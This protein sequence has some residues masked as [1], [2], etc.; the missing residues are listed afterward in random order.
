M[1]VDAGTL[2]A[3]GL[4]HHT[5]PVEVRELLSMDE[6]CVR[7]TLS[8]IRG[9][10][11]AREAFLLST[12]NRV[13]LYTVASQ[14]DRLQDYLPRGRAVSKY[15][16]WHQGPEAVRHLMRVACA[17]DSLVL[18]EP[19]I[20]GQVKS[21]MRLAQDAGS[22]GSLLHPLTRRTLS[23]AKRVRTETALGRSRVGIGNAGVD[24]ALQVFGGLKGKRA[25]L[26]GVG[27]MGRQVA[28]SLLGEGLD[29]LLV[30]NRT[31]EKAVE[32]AR[33]HGGTAVPWDRVGDYLARVDIAIAATGAR[34]HVLTRVMVERALRAR[35][36]KPIFL[37][38]LSVPRNIAADVDGLDEAYLFNV[39]DLE[40]V[41]VDGRAQRC[42]AAS[43]AGVLVDGEVQRFV[44]SLAELDL[45]KGIGTMT[46]RAEALRLQEIQR[47]HKLMNGLDEAQ[48]AAVDTLTKAL[49]K[50]LL[51]GQIRVMKTGVRAG[52]ASRISAI[53]DAWDEDE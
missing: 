3:V 47:S 51:R 27:E 49:V 53:V 16:Y 31:P 13:E 48:R 2:V 42:D 10:G 20:L 50:K 28:Q 19:Q 9:D 1:G 41:V 52:D 5:A 43:E 23:V 25:M 29:E 44:S 8:R 15:L 6:A 18:G 40:Q 45:G 30:T 39:D 17:L 36:G 11:V 34:Q 12:C 21:A 32:L 38:D 26:I 4:S 35:R 14:V 37:V 46:Q 24:L 22:L 7:D 33:R